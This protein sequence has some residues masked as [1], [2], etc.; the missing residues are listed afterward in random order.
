MKLYFA[1]RTCSLAPV[2]LAEEARLPLAL[3]QVDLRTQPRRTVAGADY[4]ALN[5]S[6]YVPVLDTGDGLLTENAAILLRLADAAPAARLV[7][8]PG[9]PQRY[10]VYA[11]LT[12]IGSELHKSFSPLF[13]P[14]EW[15]EQAVTL[16]RQRIANR[17]GRLEAQLTK[18]AFPDRRDL[19]RRRCLRLR[20]D[21]LGRSLR[22]RPRPL[23]RD[24][25]MDGAGR[26]STRRAAGD[27]SP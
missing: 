23:V 9:E 24:C 6:G 20:R 5:P 14:E 7:P 26:R 2:I 19:W 10:H 4:A 8:A 25:G 12:F 16:A 13:H 1:P 17:L 21:A 11:W 27:R 15:G 3:E 18:S 22:Y